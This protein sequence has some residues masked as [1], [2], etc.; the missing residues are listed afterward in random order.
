MV[1]FYEEVDGSCYGG[2]ECCGEEGC[3]GCY[4]EEC[5]LCVGVVC[6]VEECE[7]DVLV[8]CGVGGGYLFEFAVEW[9]CCSYG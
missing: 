2:G 4:G 1:F 5:G 8:E 6:G 7:V 3:Y 9:Y